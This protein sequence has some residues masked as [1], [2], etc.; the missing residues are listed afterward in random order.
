MEENNATGN[1]LNIDALE[2]YT[3]KCL[4]TN[5]T[6]LSKFISSMKSSY[7]H[8]TS[9]LTI[10]KI[11][12]DYYHDYQIK[13]PNDE[14]PIRLESILPK[15]NSE[16]KNK[17]LRQT[18]LKLAD[19]L[20]NGEPI[21]TESAGQNIMNF[22]SQRAGEEAINKLVLS[23]TNTDNSD[24]FKERQ[25]NAIFNCV[26]ELKQSTNICI[27]DK[28]PFNLA[29][30]SRLHEIR[31]EAL[32]DEDNNRII[33]F[34]IKS[35]NDI[36]QYDGVAV[37]SIV[38]VVATPGCFTGDTRIMT[39]DGKSETLE[40]LYNMKSKNLEVFSFDKDKRNINVS[41]AESVYLS[42]YED[43][44]VEVEIDGS[45]KIRCTLDHPFLLRNGEYKKAEF[46][47]V[48]DSLEPIRRELFKE[49][50]PD[51]KFK[52]DYEVVTNG[53]NRTEF[54]ANLTCIKKYGRMPIM[55]KEQVHH[56][57]HDK[58]NNKLENIELVDKH[59]HLSEHMKILTNKGKDSTGYKTRFGQPNGNLNHEQVIEHNKS[60]YMRKIVSES[61]KRLWTTKEYRDKHLNN[62]NSLIGSNYSKEA[63]Q[64]KRKCKALNFLNTMINTFG[65]ENVTIDNYHNLCNKLNSNYT[66]SLTHIANC[67]NVTG[68]KET[69]KRHKI[70]E[71][72]EYLEKI[73]PQ[74]LEDAKNYNHKIT[75][76]KFITLDEPVP[77][78]G[79]YNVSENHNYAI[80]LDNNEGIFVSNSGKSTFLMN[81]GLCSAS[82]GLRVAHCFIGDM[83]YLDGLI[84]YYTCYTETENSRIMIANKLLEKDIKLRKRALKKYKEGSDQFLFNERLIKEKEAQLKQNQE[85]DE[86]L[87]REGKKKLVLTSRQMAQFSE[88]DLLKLLSS[89]E[90]FMKIAQNVDIFKYASA[91]ITM[92]ALK[93]EIYSRQ[94]QKGIHYDVIIVDYDGNLKQPADSMYE[95]GG[96]IYD[97][98]K[99]LAQI[100]H[101]VVFMASQPK[102]SFW[103]NELIPI[104]ACAESS[105]KQMV[106]D[107]LITIGRPEGVNTGIRKIYVPKNRRGKENEIFHAKLNGETG[108]MYEIFQ[109]EYDALKKQGYD[110]TL[111][112]DTATKKKQEQMKQQENNNNNQAN[113]V[114][115]ESQINLNV[116]KQ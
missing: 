8:T 36:M 89:D 11:I 37:G 20:Y 32:G 51:R 70:K 87:E 9:N 62:I 66:I 24:N 72:Q 52:T 13:I 29:D 65:I 7:F 97:Q 27:D 82:Q 112:L 88:S 25:F 35:M 114:N 4:L 12:R 90:K 14:L 57:D 85:I 10:F 91:E 21:N 75:N 26:N 55:G 94:R 101:S 15:S 86:Q 61:T 42:K 80:A 33:K 3:I 1:F 111:V 105:K 98:A 54:T 96:I 48:G 110:P 16:D 84:R 67:Y 59:K 71:G 93:E 95:S 18:C 60:D 2:V 41:L 109:D 102:Q 44:L 106:M 23:M 68:F 73:W 58:L 43:K 79:L 104:E 34:Y 116:L 47:Q 108:F 107:M 92:D 100:N 69:A 115:Q 113:N 30:M 6:L 50:F 45:Y 19:D 64:Y 78:Y 83:E 40:N 31:K 28:E 46:L 77:V 63:Q 76:I 17:E 22:I 49:R 103:R 74:I 81:Q 39:L 53:D 5:Q 99:N 38:C 56:I